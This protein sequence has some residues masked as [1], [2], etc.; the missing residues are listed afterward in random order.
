MNIKTRLSKLE[1]VLAPPSKLVVELV[2]EGDAITVIK[3]GKV[4]SRA[5]LEGETAR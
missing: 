3:D 1:E 5:E 2:D 4:I